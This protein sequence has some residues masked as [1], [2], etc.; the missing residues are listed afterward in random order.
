VIDTD[1]LDATIREALGLQRDADLSALAYETSP[2]WDSVGHLQLVL[3]IEERFGIS[4]DSV[5]VASM[6]RYDQLRPLITGK[7]GIQPRSD[8][9]TPRSEGDESPS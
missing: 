7:Y 4:I 2:E 6:T 5:D 1:E 8:V 3:A 9:G